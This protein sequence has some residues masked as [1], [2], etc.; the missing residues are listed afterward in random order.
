MM[1]WSIATIAD[2]CEP[3]EQIDPRREIPGNFQ[4]VDIAG[5]DRTYKRIAEHRTV[6]GAQAPI[7]ARKVIRANDILVST[8]RPNLNTVAVVP[9]HLD[10]QIA[11]TGFC[12]LRANGAVIEPRFLFYL[13]ITS[14]FVAGLS[15]RVRGANYPAVTD[16]DIKGLRIPLPP[17]PEQRRIASILD[18]ANRLRYLRV[19]ADCK[20]KRIL[21]ALFIR[22]FG[23]PAANPMGWPV[24]Q[25]GDV[26]QEFISGGT[27]STKIKQFWTGDIPWITGA[28]L[29]DSVVV[30]GRKWI[31]QE[32]IE[33]SATQAV[34][35]G[36]LL[37][38]TRTGV[39][40][41]AKAGGNIAISQDLTGI[42]LRKG[43]NADFVAAAIR[44][45][46]RSLRDVQQGAIIKGVLRKDVEDL[47]IP[48]P[49][50]SLQQRFASSVDGNLKLVAKG[51]ESR[52]GLEALFQS[53]L[54][55][56]FSGDFGSEMPGVP[57]GASVVQ[58]GK[59]TVFRDPEP[60]GDQH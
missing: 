49:P 27:P 50:R 10:G 40:K 48:L 17:L 13:T 9:A 60:E 22:M 41:V 59:P 36:G 16:H 29:T 25:L 11:S 58:D 12:V 57:V 2:V 6:L 23:D 7:R 53:T 55:R 32:A 52:R 3:T 42:V 47:D 15:E 39:G 28:D 33:K 56:A 38:A 14:D 34:P 44:Q 30:V 51:V 20:A 19:E 35:K 31:T 5:I 45:R 18:Q 8:V 26:A 54:H 4:Y 46:A 43:V 24:A 37:L 21:Q 1:K